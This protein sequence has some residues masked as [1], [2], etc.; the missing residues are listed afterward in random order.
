MATI[1]LSPEEQY[2]MAIDELR[3]ARQRAQRVNP[4]ALAGLLM[5]DPG[6]NRAA[7]AVY[8]QQQNTSADSALA[9]TIGRWASGRQTAQEQ[10]ELA[11]VRTARQ[12]ELADRR[13]AQANRRA[14]ENAALQRTLEQMRGERRQTAADLRFEREKELLGMRS[15]AAQRRAETMAQRSKPLTGKQLDEIA[16]MREGLRELEGMSYEEIAQAM[17][18]PIGTVRS[19]IFRAREAIDRHVQPLMK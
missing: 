11:D 15:E 9:R 4:A 14:A 1:R 12:T 18:C 6:A 7:R 17:D 3:G 10:Q 16:G 5:S 19:R 2:Q 13:E 8:E